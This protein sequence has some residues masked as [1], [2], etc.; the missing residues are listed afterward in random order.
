MECSGFKPGVAR[1]K[2]KTDGSAGP[3]RPPPK[4]NYRTFILCIFKV[5]HYY[6]AG[7][8]VPY[9]PHEASALRV[10]VDVV[11]EAVGLVVVVG[12]ERLQASIL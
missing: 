11:G 1:W 7:L 2:E 4:K 6:F 10:H 12:L 3:W 5:Y 9:G 8:N